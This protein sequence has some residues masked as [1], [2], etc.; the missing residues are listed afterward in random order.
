[1]KGTILQENLIKFLSIAQKALPTKNTSH[2]VLN[3]FFFQ[4]KSGEIKVTASSLETTIT[5]KIPGKIL[6]DG[7]ILIPAKT[8]LSFLPSFVGEK[9]STEGDNKQIKLEGNTS[10]VNLKTED[11]GDYPLTGF[12][13]KKTTGKISK[14]LLKQI[15][16]KVCFSASLDESRAILTGVLIKQE[17]E[18]I[19][20]AATDGFRLSLFEGKTKEKL[21]WSDI[22][23]PAKVLFDIFQ[24]L[25]ESDEKELT[26]FLNE[27]K[28][29]ISFSIP[30]IEI[31]TRTI[32]GNFPSYQKIIPQDFETKI[33]FS[34]E[35]F[36]RAVKLA[37]VFAR[38]AA[39]IIKLNSTTDGFFVSSTSPQSGENRTKL[40]VKIEGEKKIEAAFNYRFLI[41]LLN[42]SEDEEVVF[43]TSGALTPGVFKF[44]KNPNF[45]HIIM[46]VRLQES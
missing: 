11:K 12:S 41:D 3:N 14:N 1:M 40:D 23:L 26:V 32:E 27:E 15:V 16:E 8:L 7:E 33:V 38:E 9:I 6:Q 43:E 34:R 21:P 36:L 39:N 25:K 4:A 2:P 19:I 20:A 5:V 17:E 46:P 30:G 29:Q 13:D 45:L 28:T 22:V 18:K 35:D 37:S 42:S 31:I 24:I 44:P 10:K